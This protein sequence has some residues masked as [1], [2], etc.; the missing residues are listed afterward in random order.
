MEV[1][2]GDT[3]LWEVRL[4]SIT[5]WVVS[6]ISLFSAQLK[7]TRKLLRTFKGWESGSRALQVQSLSQN[8]KIRSQTMSISNQV[9]DVTTH[10]ELA[11]ILILSCYQYILLVKYRIKLMGKL[12]LMYQMLSLRAWRIFFGRWRWD[13]LFRSIWFWQTVRWNKPS[14]W[15]D[16]TAKIENTHKCSIYSISVLLE[17]EV[18]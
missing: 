2:M 14:I 9:I 17:E 1:S 4:T 18:D 8:T 12:L 3:I 10:E 6:I 15:Q 16:V 5:P 7:A 13:S 11:N